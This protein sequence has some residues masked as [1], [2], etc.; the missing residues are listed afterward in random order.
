MAP[1][2]R[3]RCIHHRLRFSASSVLTAIAFVNGKFRPIQNRHPSTEIFAT[4]DY[5]GDLYSC[6][7]LSAHLLTVGLLGTRVKYNQNYFLFIPLFKPVD[8]FSRLM[9]QMT[10][11]RARMCLF[12]ICSPY[13]GSKPLQTPNFGA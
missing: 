13:R 4:D 6:A 10:Q 7:K 9:A 8:G 11:T 2:F 5:V 12:G 3:T 1:L